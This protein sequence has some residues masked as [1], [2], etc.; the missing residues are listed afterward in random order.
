[1]IA[2]PRFAAGYSQPRNVTPLRV[3]NSISSREGS[4]IVSKVFHST[5]CKEMAIVHA[6]I[7]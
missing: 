1:M 6:F 7:F 2:G 5:N 3:L 4:A